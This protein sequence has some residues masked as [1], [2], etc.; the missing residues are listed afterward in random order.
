MTKQEQ[1]DVPWRLWKCAICGCEEVES[2][3][4]VKLNTNE[5]TDDFGDGDDYNWCPKCEE[6]GPLTCE[7]V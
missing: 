7:E 5:I 6:H 1:T 4:W 2:A 3:S